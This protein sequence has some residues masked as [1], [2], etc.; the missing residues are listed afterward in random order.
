M[1][2]ANGTSSDISFDLELVA[3]AP[4]VTV[5]LPA[6]FPG[7]MLRLRSR[8][9]DAA[10]NWSALSEAVYYTAA[11]ASSANLAVTEVNYN[12]RPAEPSLGEVA[13][14]DPGDFEFVELM[15]TSRQRVALD[16]VKFA[17]GIKLEFPLGTFL[18]PGE[19]AVVVKN[20]AA[21]RSRYGNGPR[22]LGTFT[23]SLGND[24][25][26]TILRDA[27]NQLLSGF[28]YNDSGDWPGRADGGGATL[29]VIDPAGDYN[30]P[31]N[32]RSS[33]EYNGTPGAAG[34]GPVP[35]VVINEVLTNTDAPALDSVELFNPSNF[36]VDVSGWYLSDSS[37]DYRRY[38]LPDG[39]TLAPG[40]YLLLNETTLGFSLDG[41]GDDVWLMQ[42]DAVT[43][44]LTRF[45]DRVELDAAATGESWGR[46][47]SGSPEANH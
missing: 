38:R 34:S 30:D 11:A 6:T 17:F 39:T 45:A 25:Q 22:V 24:G 44:K 16:G 43:H 26:L 47:A 21:F 40:G 1:H 35:G 2:Q 18:D 9:R 10:G 33:R 27:R 4:P 8:A 36:P 13:T 37:A 5:T 28:H 15:N 12:P 46:W 31:H 7:G 20:L 3:P 29:E 23:G 41:E 42:A 32:W 14:T 19:R